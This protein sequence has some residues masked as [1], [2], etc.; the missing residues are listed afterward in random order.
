MRFHSPHSR[1]SEYSQWSTLRLSAAKRYQRPAAIVR[2]AAAVIASY[3]AAAR[4]AIL[5]ERLQLQ[6][7]G[8][9]P[10]L[11][12]TIGGN[13]Y[14]INKIEK[15][16]KIKFSLPSRPQPL[17]SAMNVNYTF[18]YQQYQQEPRNPNLMMMRNNGN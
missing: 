13:L 1:S 11:C 4:V 10:A 5:S 16:L 14:F 18:G 8:Q 6:R 9:L 15:I 3:R 17:M 12:T 7:C 2:L